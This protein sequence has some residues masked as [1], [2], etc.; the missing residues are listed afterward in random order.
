MRW[1]VRLATP[2]G[3]TVLDPF[4]GSGTTLEAARLEG[5]DVV[6]IEREAEYLPLIRARLDRVE[7]QPANEPD[8]GVLDFGDSA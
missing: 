3:G 7:Q 1:L 6:G 4:A 2:A 8:Q 5:F